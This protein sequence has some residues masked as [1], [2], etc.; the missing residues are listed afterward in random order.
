MISRDADINPKKVKRKALFL[1][2][3]GTMA[4]GIALYYAVSGE[5]SGK[6]YA[7]NTHGKRALFVPVSRAEAPADFRHANNF[8]WALCVISFGIGAAG[9]WHYRDLKDCD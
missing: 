6:T 9:I 1:I 4:G 3:I 7:L 8:F 2:V 5:M